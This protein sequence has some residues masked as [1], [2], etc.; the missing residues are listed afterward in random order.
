MSN[1]SFELK[2]YNPSGAIDTSVLHA[3]RLDNLAG[4]TIC[5]IS[6]GSWED[7]RTFPYIRELLKR[8]FPT[9]KIIPLTEAIG[10][11]A[12]SDDLA[13]VAKVA[14]EK[15]CQAAIVGNAG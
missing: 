7:A 11:R 1:G 13:L 3:P 6:N 9:A 5:E 14:K 4:K 10:S 15:G 2:V 12:Q 8:Q